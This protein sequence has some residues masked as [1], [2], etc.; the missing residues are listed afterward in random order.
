[1]A[2]T[3]FASRTG[4]PSGSV[5]LTGRGRMLAVFVLVLAYLSL[6]VAVVAIG[7]GASRASAPA[8]PDRSVVVQPRDT[9]WSIAERHLPDSDRFAAIDQIRR[10]NAIDDYTVHPGQTLALPPAR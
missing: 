10:L 3:G 1:M 9:L 8:G 7:A 2:A 5:R 6:A 4:R